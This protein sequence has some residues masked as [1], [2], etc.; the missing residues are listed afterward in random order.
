MPR[1][2]A[3]KMAG[4]L[5]A[6]AIVVVAMAPPAWAQFERGQVSGV[7]KD[8]TGGVTPG[9]T[10]TATNLQ[11]QVARTAVTDGTGFYTFPN[12]QPG[13]YDVSAELQASR[14]P[15]K[16]TCSSTPRVR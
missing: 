1:Y 5:A 7:V 14:R 12:L 16:T 8:S 13:R 10:L 11:T 2:F 4:C 3:S 9:V 6:A 15:F